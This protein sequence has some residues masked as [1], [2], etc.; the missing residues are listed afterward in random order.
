M[1]LDNL[2]APFCLPYMNSLA[3]LSHSTSTH[4]LHPL[5]TFLPC[6]NCRRPPHPNPLPFRYACT[7]WVLFLQW[8]PRLNLTGILAAPR[9]VSR[10]CFKKKSP[11]DP[12][13]SPLSPFLPLLSSSYPKKNLFVISQ[14]FSLDTTAVCA[15]KTSRPVCA[16]CE[17]MCSG[18]LWVYMHV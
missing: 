13:S 2:S 6:S 17:H 18:S 10:L 1:H 7:Q 5:R 16:F 14:M 4:W 3:A 11:L 8:F 15:W 9:V 12:S